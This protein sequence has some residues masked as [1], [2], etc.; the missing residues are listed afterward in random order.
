MLRFGLTFGSISCS[1]LFHCIQLY[2]QKAEV[3]A[4]WQQT[5]LCNHLVQPPCSSRVR[6]SRTPRKV[7]SRVLVISMDGDFTLSLGDLLH[8]ISL[9]SCGISCFSVCFHRF[10]AW[11]SDLPAHPSWK[12]ECHLLSYLLQE[13]LLTTMTFQKE[14]ASQ[15]SKSAPSHPWM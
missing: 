12:S 15:W 9:C 10:L 3:P 4:F 13:P 5:D 7:S 2:T 1:E 14:L 6:Q 8:C 11:S